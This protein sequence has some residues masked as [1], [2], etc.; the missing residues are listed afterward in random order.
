MLRIYLRYTVVF[1]FVLSIIST[2]VGTVAQTHEPYWMF[3]FNASFD[4]L[5]LS[6]GKITGTYSVLFDEEFGDNHTI[7][8]GRYWSPSKIY[9]NFGFD[10]L[11]EESE[12]DYMRFFRSFETPVEDELNL[13]MFPSWYPW[14][15][16]VTGFIVA[17]NVT[18]EFEHVFVDIRLSPDVESS[19]SVS[20][21][22]EMLNVDSLQSPFS[23]ISY[24]ELE[25][26]RKWNNATIY[27]LKLSFQRRQPML[28]R[29]AL[30]FWLPA[31]V[32]AIMLIFFWILYLK[33]RKAYP[34]IIVGVASFQ[35][36]F[37]GIFVTG[38]P[39]IIP[40]VLIL[41]VGGV[42][43]S[44]V[45]VAAMYYLAIR[46]IGVE[47]KIDEIRSLMGGMKVE[48]VSS[49]RVSKTSE[50]ISVNLGDE[51][52]I[53]DHESGRK[54]SGTVIDK[55]LVGKISYRPEIEGLFT[56]Q[57]LIEL[58]EPLPGR[59]MA[60]EN[61]EGFP[62]GVVWAASKTHAVATKIFG[63]KIED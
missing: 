10:F 8:I 50:E 19:W 59:P 9:R 20:H 44:L 15:H 24:E 4:R 56:D 33:R 35:A 17:F 42:V 18:M 41:L 62:I 16:Y 21:N 26:V 23:D 49:K 27:A 63:Q 34:A 11:S 60:L 54:F 7:P 53:I 22:F 5:Y 1:L 52:S 47:E 32:T 37:I 45:S 25:G 58:D 2:D 14:D 55:D 43:F 39:P 12:G 30:T 28:T 57:M 46:K 61:D 31:V 51:V 13:T 29:L 40:N 38:G 36:T 3:I 48:S 6:T